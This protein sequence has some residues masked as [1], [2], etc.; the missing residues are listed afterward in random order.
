M[1]GPRGR[2]G[3]TGAT[4]YTGYTG[5]TGNT[6]YT[7]ATGVIGVQGPKGQGRNSAAALALES[8][9]GLLQEAIMSEQSDITSAHS[10]LTVVSI[11]LIVWGV[12]VT[13]AIAIL[14]VVAFSKLRHNRMLDIADWPR[15]KTSSAVDKW[16]RSD[17]ESGR[18][19]AAAADDVGDQTEIDVS[20]IVHRAALS[21]AGSEVDPDE[22][23][24]FDVR[25]R[26]GVAASLVDSESE[27]ELNSRDVPRSVQ[28]MK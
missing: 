25:L 5:Y 8:Q 2:S 28:P 1:T 11:V 10:R 23:P 27:D 7:G 6:G 9:A 12:V 3:G 26:A 4:G 20:A 15:A 22:L 18:D 19:V 16:R 17:A 21:A 14:V 13:L 24:P